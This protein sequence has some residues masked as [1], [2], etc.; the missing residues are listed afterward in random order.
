MLAG[1]VYLVSCDCAPHFHWPGG[2]FA[3]CLTVFFGVSGLCNW[4]HQ[5]PTC[6]T[7]PPLFFFF[8][9]FF[10]P[11]VMNLFASVLFPFFLSCWWC[12]L[13]FMCLLYSF[14][15]LIK[16]LFCLHPFISGAWACLHRVFTLVPLTFG[17]E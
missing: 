10:T 16:L 9:F 12:V 5:P 8:S 17:A 15:E 1:Y 2:G 7:W 11:A 4:Q 13:L 14:V 3:A 6:F